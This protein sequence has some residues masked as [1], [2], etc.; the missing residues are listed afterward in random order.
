VIANYVCE[1]GYSVHGNPSRTCATDGSWIGSEDGN[2]VCE[3]MG[4]TCELHIHKK[5]RYNCI[6]LLHS[7]T[8]VECNPLLNI[9]YG[10]VHYSSVDTT[11]IEPGDV[12]TYSC[13][14]PYIL[15][16]ADYRICMNNGTWSEEQ[17]QC[18][19]ELY[20]NYSLD[21]LYSFITRA[22]SQSFNIACS[23]SV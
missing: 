7:A 11:T 22:T 20:Y 5:N 21:R 10:H 18:I 8:L 17:P 16:G 3:G 12:V 6:K 9:P 15:Q 2:P 19:G 4:L 23:K 13:D 1:D 14:P